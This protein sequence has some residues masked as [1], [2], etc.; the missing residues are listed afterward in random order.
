MY[1]AFAGK[2][3]TDGGR[4]GAKN[5]FTE[6]LLAYPESGLAASSVQF[7][8]NGLIR[9]GAGNMCEKLHCW[10]CGQIS[11]AKKN[12]QTLVNEQGKV[13]YLSKIPFHGRQSSCGGPTGRTRHA[14]RIIWSKPGIISL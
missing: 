10:P 13:I 3:S 8:W 5:R 6:S 2:G 11:P 7:A 14:Y 4:G 12:S 9:G 1:S